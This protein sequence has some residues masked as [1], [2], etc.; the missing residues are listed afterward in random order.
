MN[1]PLLI[2]LDAEESRTPELERALQ[3]KGWNAKWVSPTDWPEMRE[4]GL[5]PSALVATA[6][7]RGT[8]S[9]QPIYD[10]KNKNPLMPLILIG[11]NTIGFPVNADACIPNGA[12]PDA[13]LETLKPFWP[14][15]TSEETIQEKE[16]EV[17]GKYKLIRKIASGGMADIFQA[18]QLEPQGFNRI[19]AIKRIIQQHQQDPIYIQMLLDEAN[20]AG[21]LSHQNIVQIFD[22]GIESGNHYIAM[23]YVDGD[24]LSTLISKAKGLG[25]TFPEPIAASIIIQAAEALDYVHRRRDKEGRSLKL[26]HKDISPHNILVS[27]EGVVKVIDFGIAKTANQV[28][29]QTGET[30]LHGKLQYMSPEQ[31][32][33]TPMDHRTDIYSLGLVLFEL[34]TAEY[35]FQADGEFGLLEKVR[36]GMVQDIRKANPN[37]SKPIARIFNKATQKNLSSRYNSTHNMALD[38]KAYLEH[39]K[40]DSLESDA[41][42]FIKMLHTAQI[43]TKAFV[44]SRFSP[45]TSDTALP[46]EK[47]DKHLAKKQ[48]EKKKG[49]RK[50]KIVEGKKRPVWILPAVYSLLVLLAYLLWLSVNL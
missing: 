12:T 47:M 18:E 1:N 25:I 29:D 3:L 5:E 23:E 13:W 42:A 22:L 16:P 27:K 38:L 49:K 6:S 19:L 14:A 37:V 32:L 24:N 11:E 50:E 4:D 41:I 26:F 34:L 35:C 17:F 21:S 31:S 39:L 10:L 48:G 15:A 7:A 9:M 8:A 28:L 33:G 44:T 36:T 2:I 43:Q 30:T 20:V 45:I 46:S 40:L